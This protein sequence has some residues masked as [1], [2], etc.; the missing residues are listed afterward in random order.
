MSFEGIKDWLLTWLVKYVA[1]LL[2]PCQFSCDVIVY[3]A[4]LH[5]GLTKQI[6]KTNM[7]EWSVEHGGHRH[8]QL[9][10]NKMTN[11]W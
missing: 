5:H 8:L 6:E 9:F 4:K 2:V 1:L 7:L 3:E 11:A 10:Q